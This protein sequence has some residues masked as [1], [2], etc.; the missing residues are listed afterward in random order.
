MISTVTIPVD[1]LKPAQLEQVDKWLRLVLWENELPGNGKVQNFEIHRSKG[2]LL[3]DNGDVKMLQGVREIFE[4][5]DAP[6]SSDAASTSGKI[7]FI[8][9]HVADVDFEH[10]F[11][12]V[13][14]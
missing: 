2:R 7:V 5:I 9:R 11:R 4:V 10:S 14:N 1:K 13:V 3:F 12:S 6:A 8:G